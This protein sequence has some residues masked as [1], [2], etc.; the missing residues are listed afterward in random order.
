MRWWLIILLGLINFS[1]EAEDE[2]ATA[3]IQQSQTTNMNGFFAIKDYATMSERDI[4]EDEKNRAARTK[5]VMQYGY[6]IAKSEIEKITGQAEN[7]E[8][9]FDK[10]LAK[11]QD[12]SNNLHDEFMTN[13][14]AWLLVYN[15]VADLTAYE[16]IDLMTDVIKETNTYNALSKGQ[17]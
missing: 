10:L 2:V 13:T 6:K 5:V 12:G 17:R 11:A 7:G 3:R 14:A 15:Q 16:A 8:S 1:A 4:A 9:E